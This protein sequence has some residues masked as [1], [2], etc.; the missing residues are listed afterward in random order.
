[1]FLKDKNVTINNVLYRLL[2]ITKSVELG[3]EP[4]PKKTDFKFLKE[5][6]SGSFGRVF[7]VQHNKTNAQFALKTID[8]R[9][10][11]NEQE[12]ANFLREVEIIYKIHHPNIV[13]LYGHFEDNIYCYLL[14]EYI[15]GGEL[16]SYIPE[17][18]E[19]IL[20]T[21]QVASI[22]RDVISAIYYLHHMNPPVMH[23]DIKPENVLINSKLKAKLTDFGWSN[24]FKPGEKRNSICGTPIYLAPEMI[25]RIG[26]DEKVDIW[27]VGVLLFE[28]LTGDQAWAGESIETVQYNICNLKISWPDK[29]NKVAEDLIS[30]ILKTN[31]KERLSLKDILSHSFFTQYF[32]NPTSCL[33]AP[34]N[35]KYKP[36]IISKDDPFIWNFINGEENYEENQELKSNSNYD[37][38]FDIIDKIQT[39]YIELPK[40][41]DKTI[42]SLNKSNKNNFGNALSHNK[43]DS[44]IWGA[45]SYNLNEYVPY[46]IDYNSLFDQ[47]FLNN[48]PNN[49]I[50]PIEKN[51]NIRLGN[52]NTEFGNIFGYNQQNNY[53]T[54]FN[55]FKEENNINQKGKEKQRKEIE[56]IISTD[57]YNNNNKIDSDKNLQKNDLQ[58]FSKYQDYFF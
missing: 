35:K 44:D 2:P 3:L 23:R 19:Q 6:G 53:N 20:D 50:K 4:E 22:V 1:M 34:D 48:N 51:D 16:Y 5:L 49:T 28:L 18:G 47:I 52:N 29:M 10:L 21:K 8:K 32:A 7:L 41:E 45:N 25:K 43:N 37:Y 40:E 12:K 17:S 27:S 38:L 54:I 56:E 58:D 9:L 57:F 33:K 31:P 30:K 26:H 39:E 24:Y 42:S 55:D 15:E 46:P 11:V 13:K 14:M 36:F